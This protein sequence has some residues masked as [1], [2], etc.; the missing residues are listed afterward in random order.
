MIDQNPSALIKT[1]LSKGMLLA[2]AVL[3]VLVA[4]LV[5]AVVVVWRMW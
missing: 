2:A 5:A 3:C 4:A 1:S